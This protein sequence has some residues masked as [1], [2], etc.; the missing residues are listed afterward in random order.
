MRVVKLSQVKK[1]DYLIRGTGVASITEA[2][3]ARGNE[4]VIPEGMV[5]IKG[6]YVRGAKKY[7]VSRF[8]DSNWESLAKGDALVLVG[9]TF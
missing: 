4:P 8:T 2:T 3:R 9:F 7:S 5:W 6:D 1:G